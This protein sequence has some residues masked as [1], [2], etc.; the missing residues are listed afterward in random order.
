M[1]KDIVSLFVSWHCLCLP[2]EQTQIKAALDSA[3]GSFLAFDPD[4]P[5]IRF[6]G[7]ASLNHIYFNKCSSFTLVFS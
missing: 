5:M 3:R 7:T 4:L 1:Q 2:Q 6:C